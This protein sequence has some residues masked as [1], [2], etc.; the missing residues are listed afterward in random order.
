MEMTWELMLFTSLYESMNNK[1]A[2]HGRSGRPEW[3]VILK[4]KIGEWKRGQTF[5]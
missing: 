4:Y 1:V 3:C 5:G 2:V